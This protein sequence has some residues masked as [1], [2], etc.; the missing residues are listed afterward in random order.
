MRNPICDNLGTA[1][2]FAKKE[3]RCTCLDNTDFK[4]HKNHRCPFY[5]SKEVYEEQKKR[6]KK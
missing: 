2:C 4:K 5:K 3:G 1:D 6:F